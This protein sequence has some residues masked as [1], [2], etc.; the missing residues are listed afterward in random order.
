VAHDVGFGSTESLRRHFLARTG[1]SPRSYRETFRARPA[2]SA[3]R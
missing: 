1:I 3:S 2:A